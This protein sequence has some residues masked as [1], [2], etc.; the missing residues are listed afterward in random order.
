ML[1]ITGSTPSIPPVNKTPVPAQP[2]ITAQPTK[3]SME[4]KKVWVDKSCSA[5]PCNRGKWIHGWNVWFCQNPSSPSSQSVVVASYVCWCCFQQCESTLNNNVLPCLWSQAAFERAVRKEFDF[6]REQGVVSNE[7]AS[8]AL[9]KAKEQFMWLIAGTQL[10]YSVVIPPYYVLH[11]HMF[12]WTF[13]RPR[14]S[15]LSP[16][17]IDFC[18]RV[19]KV[20]HKAAG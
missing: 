7:A 9:M 15:S 11:A 16:E 5:D 20:L 12:N 13:W 14:K 6:L 19:Q 17:L 3:L 4:E 8:R 10:M 1:S 2:K 18:K